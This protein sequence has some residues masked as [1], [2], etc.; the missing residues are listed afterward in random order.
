MNVWTEQKKVKKSITQFIII[1]N[2]TV[3]LLK[4]LRLNTAMNQI[5]DRS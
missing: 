5:S 1:F 3:V 2:N 4:L